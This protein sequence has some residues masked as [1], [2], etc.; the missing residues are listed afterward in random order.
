MDG[1][2][3]PKTSSI[4]LQTLCAPCHNRCLYCLLSWDGK[5]IGAPWDRSAAFAKRFHDWIRETRPE[6]KFDFS[7]GSSMEHPRLME[8]IDFMNSIGSVMGRFLQLDGMKLRT[9]NELEQLYSSL[10]SHGV[11]NVDFTFYGTETYHDHFAARKGDYDLMIRSIRFAL[12]AGIAVTCDIPL[13]SENIGMADPVVSELRSLGCTD[14][15]FRIP[16]GEG[17]GEL[18]ESI[19][20]KKHEFDALS[21]SLKPLLNRKTFRTEGEW[22][23]LASQG[24][25][26]KENQRTLLISLTNENIEAMENTPFERII[27][28]AERLDDEYYA[29]F[30]SFGELAQLYGEKDGERMFSYRD[31]FHFYRKRYAL[32]HGIKVYDVT[33]ERYTGSR[34]F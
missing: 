14:I 27:A 23:E 31:L 25:A 2:F 26:P 8:A 5:V 30:P 18:I 20:L 10:A 7:I 11:E 24:E 4:M 29:A 13:T 22:L 34:R 9:D 3:K 15:R 32:E 33:D 19:R 12:A 28:E 17:R 1:E 21:D 6:L 16:H